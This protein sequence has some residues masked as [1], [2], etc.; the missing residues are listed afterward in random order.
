MNV[1]SPRRLHRSG[2]TLIELLVVIAII[3]ILAAILFPVFAQAREKARTASCLSNTKEIGI[4]IQMYAQDYDETVV[5]WFVTTGKPR[6]NWRHDLNS[7]V[8]LLQP[9]IKNGAP[10]D[11]PVVAGGVPPTGMMSCP[12][13]DATKR[14]QAAAAPDCDNDPLT[15]YYPALWYHSHFGIGFGAAA[16]GGSGTQTDPFYYFAGSD[17]RVHVMTLVEINRPAETAIVTDG[18]TGVLNNGSYSFGTTMG[19]EAA[20]AHNGGGN[21]TWMDGHSKWIARNSERYLDKDS[22][23]FYFKKFYSVDR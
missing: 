22:N 7:W 23:G 12:S 6:D 5:P 11:P 19:C 10:I 18:M 17:V 13:F 21:I 16:K 9:Y 15:I 3:A 14:S 20:N 4:A 8:Q 1:H 2:F